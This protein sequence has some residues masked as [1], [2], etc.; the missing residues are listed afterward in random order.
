MSAAGFV[1]IALAVLVGYEAFQHF[2][3]GVATAQAASTPSPATSPNLA[4]GNSA[5]AGSLGS[6]FTN[7]YTGALLSDQPVYPQGTVLDQQTLTRMAQQ[8]GFSGQGLQNVLMVIQG[9]SGGDPNN[10]YRGPEHSDAAGLLQF[11]SSTAQSWGLSNRLDPLASLQ[12]AYRA[13]NGGT[14]WCPSPWGPHF[15]CGYS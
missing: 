15:G 1:L 6:V 4:A 13:T 8:A 12:A 10:V 2:G 3:L 9:E 14:R 7:N 5:A 11:I